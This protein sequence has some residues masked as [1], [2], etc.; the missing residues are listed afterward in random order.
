M[1]PKYATC[2]C[3]TVL[4]KRSMERH[5]STSKH[6]RDLIQKIVK[7]ATEQRKRMADAVEDQSL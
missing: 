2:E 3:G 7:L 6:R 1:D 4:L 5:L